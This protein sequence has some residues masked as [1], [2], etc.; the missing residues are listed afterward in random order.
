MTYIIHKSSQT[1]GRVQARPSDIATSF[2][3]YE[4]LHI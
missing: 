3:P 2:F 4:K 1:V